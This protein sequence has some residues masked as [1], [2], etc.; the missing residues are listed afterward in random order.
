V[1]KD[2][3]SAKLQISENKCKFW[4]SEN[5][6]IYFLLSRDKIRRIQIKS[7][8]LVVIAIKYVWHITK[9]V[10]TFATGINQIVKI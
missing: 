6:N 5:R 7:V 10:H 4:S 8:L 1:Q 9:K 3:V 2:Y